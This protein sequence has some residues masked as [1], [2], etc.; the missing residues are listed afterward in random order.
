MHTGCHRYPDDEIE[1]KI[2]EMRVDL[3]SK[4]VTGR[5]KKTDSHSVAEMRDLKNAKAGAAL[6]ISSNYVSG[7]LCCGE[8]LR[9]SVFLFLLIAYPVAD[10]EWNMVVCGG[11]CLSAGGAAIAGSP[12]YTAI[13]RRHV[14]RYTECG[15][16]QMNFGAK[17]CPH[18]KS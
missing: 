12:P 10:R 13:H 4:K 2:A 5:G 14:P 6:G 15:R 18:C 17:R 16:F 9:T 7:T 1:E 3:S 11:A 8:C